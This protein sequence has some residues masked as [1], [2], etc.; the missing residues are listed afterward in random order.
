MPQLFFARLE[1]SDDPALALTRITVGFGDTPA[2]NADLVPAAIVAL[3]D[4]NLPGGNGLLI[5]GPMSIPVAFAIAHAIS[6]RFAFIAVWDPKLQ[7]Y[8]TV[9]SHSPD[10]NPGD[11]FK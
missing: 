10:A 6:H 7:H 4:L 1:K 8:V 3:S 11:L 2:T 5:N 9:I